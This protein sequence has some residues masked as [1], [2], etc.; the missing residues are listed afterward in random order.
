MVGVHIRGMAF[1]DQRVEVRAGTTVEW[2]NDDPL[3][4]TVTAD[5]GSFTSPLI[6]PGQAWRH[7]F[8]R[9]GTYSFHC[10]PH[11]FMTGVVVVR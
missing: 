4:H 3:G 1:H 10:T 6:A 5:D 9:P 8:D 2:H 7:S 11:P